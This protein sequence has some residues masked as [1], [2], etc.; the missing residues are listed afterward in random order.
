MATFSGSLLNGDWPVFTQAEP[1][2]EAL[3]AVISSDMN[4][5]TL[6]N[7]INYLSLGFFYID[8]NFTK[9]HTVQ[10][11]LKLSHVNCLKDV[12]EKEGICHQENAGVAIGLGEGW[13]QMKKTTPEDC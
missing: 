1:V 3:L 7:N 13:S 8:V 10:R 4:G 5:L 6:S 11:P 2:S 12:F 9:Q